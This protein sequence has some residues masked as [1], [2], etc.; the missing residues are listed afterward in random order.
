MFESSLLPES[1]TCTLNKGDQIRFHNDDWSYITEPGVVKNI[2]CEGFYLVEIESAGYDHNKCWIYKDDELELVEEK[3]METTFELEMG[4]HVV[5]TREGNRYLLV[6]QEGDTIIGLNLDDSTT[7]VTLLLDENLQDIED[8]RF[9]IKRVYEY[10]NCGFSKIKEKLSDPIWERKEVK[11]M[12]V[13][14]L[15]NALNIPRGT[16]R[17]KGDE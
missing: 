6:K 16:L 17:I 10:R 3:K 15:E 2:I 14:E 5:E 4:K 1:L 8:Y 12:T 9:D 11:E 13:A 7:Y